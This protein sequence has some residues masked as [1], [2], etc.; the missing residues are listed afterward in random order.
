M[1]EL[2]TT[3][4]ADSPMRW[5]G[6]IVPT[7]AASLLLVILVPVPPGLMDVLLAG[8]IALAAVVFLTTL[9]VSSPMEF[10]VFPSL[11]LGAT[12]V[13]LVLNI[14]TTRLILTAGEGGRTLG[15]AHLA[16]GEVIWSFS[17]FV[18]AGS[19][20]VGV[21]LFAILA[22]IQFV[23]I[24]KGAARISEVAAR[25]VLDA[26][27]GRQM[28][29]DADLSAGLIDEAQARRRRRE[30]SEQADF[31]GAMDGA[32]K[33][34][35]GDA[36]AAVLITLVNLFGG[37]YMGLVQ[38]GWGWG[39]TVGLFTRLTIG[40]GL[41]TQVPAL[42][43]SVSAALM[44][45]RTRSPSNFN[46][47]VVRQ[48]TARPA[49]LAVTAVF[50]GLL[51]MT[52]LPR[53][54]LGLLA[55]GCIGL[56]WILQRRRRLCEPVEQKVTMTASATSD[57]TLQRAVQVPL[58]EIELGYALIRLTDEQQG[59]DLLGRIAALRAELAERL[60][61]VLPP[62]TVRD[63]L[64]V[65]SHL[66]RVLLR[67]SAVG[68]GRIQPGRVLAV[69]SAEM[70]HDYPGPSGNWPGSD[71][72]GVWVRR[73]DHAAAQQAGLKLHEPRDVMLAE[74][75]RVI[76]RHTDELLSR[77]RV[78]EMLD[79]LADRAEAIVR[80]VR[81]R[82][83]AGRVQRVLQQLLAEGV[84][85]R[86]LE[87]ILEALCE[88]AEQTSELSRQVAGVRLAMRRGICAELADTDGV[89]RCVCVEA[90]L[91]DALAESID[92]E[93]LDDLRMSLETLMKNGRRPIV[94]S[95]DEVRMTV[96]QQ[97]KPE[98]PEVAVLSKSEAIEARMETF[99]ECPA[100]ALTAE[101]DCKIR[102][103]K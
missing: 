93:A 42:L 69:G 89:I 22:V 28:G 86:D 17:E 11:L 15:E 77:Q 3:S 55:V 90:D 75:R 97:L 63:N 57:G 60:G 16:A 2:G 52:K 29:I 27:P 33:F 1:T 83:S 38:Y 37:L 26:L 76:R 81:E 39:R 59:G 88:A 31:Y 68:G 19:L 53:L 5:R 30:I 84:S 18:A 70:L 99:Q 4:H 101:P 43:V 35:R 32:S 100:W 74:L 48:L 80:D 7:L 67:G 85:I 82:L 54:P 10:S 78:E 49:A 13:R 79:G 45:T 20:A 95:P 66:Y 61:L 71:Q 58:M 40:D 46:E 103:S 25:F 56:A 12:L 14:A 87:G 65:G 41:T 102:N 64:N 21:I 51:A 6:L 98:I 36:V 23:V 91:A 9:F 8:N 92:T 73:S 96:W 34:L 44:V 94:I 47:L 50:L 72:P 24:T 62:V